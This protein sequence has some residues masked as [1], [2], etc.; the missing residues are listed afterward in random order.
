MIPGVSALSVG[1]GVDAGA[2]LDVALPAGA[3]PESIAAAV[4]AALSDGRPSDG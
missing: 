2:G 4:W 3:T 1:V